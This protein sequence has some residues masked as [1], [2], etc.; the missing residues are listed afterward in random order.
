MPFNCARTRACRCK[1]AQ[2]CSA[3]RAL[4]TELAAVAAGVLLGGLVAPPHVQMGRRL[5]VGV[6]EQGV[7]VN[8]EEGGLCARRDALRRAAGEVGPG[9][10]RATWD[11]RARRDRFWR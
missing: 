7:V 8:Q 1:S 3:F 5:W 6:A 11:H 2:T 10:I 9:G 4:A